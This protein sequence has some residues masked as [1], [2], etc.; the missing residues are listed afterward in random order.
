MNK[1]LHSL[2]SSLKVMC[3]LKRENLLVFFLDRYLMRFMTCVVTVANSYV[4]ML[5]KHEMD[6]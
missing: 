1:M 6:I 5:F 2:S 4:L 3:N